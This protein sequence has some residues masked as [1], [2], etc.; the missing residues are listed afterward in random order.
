MTTGSARGPA[1][2]MLQS[3]D[4][5][6][7]RPLLIDALRADPGDHEVRYLLAVCDYR[8]GRLD[9]AKVEFGEV[10]ERN[11]RDCRGY[12]GLGLVAESQNDV[13]AAVRAFR[14]ALEIDGRF[15]PARQK[16][17]ALDPEMAVPS[18]ATADASEVPSSI[19]RPVRLRTLVSPVVRLIR[20]V[21]LVVLLL[22]LTLSLAYAVVAAWSLL[23]DTENIDVDEAKY[24]GLLFA[25]AALVLLVLVRVAWRAGA[26]RLRGV[27]RQVGHRQDRAPGGGP[28]SAG[29]LVHA[30][31]FTLEVTDANRHRVPLVAVE[32]NGK[33]MR[34]VV[35]NGEEVD[36]RGRPARGNYL[37]AS[38]ARVLSTGQ[39]VTVRGSTVP[40]RIGAVLVWIPLLLVLV[41]IVLSVAALFR[42]S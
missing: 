8:L 23:F 6:R 40:N 9:E 31:S 10:L 15:E 38:H 25:G 14:S 33:R 1:Y 20:T 2:E 4:P 3:G 12:H 37:R 7:A 32:M 18:R 28:R 21:V 35:Q 11:P 42:G 36:V 27:V 22:A 29:V 13:P 41:V 34:G 17:Q 5:A 16:L 24:F 19:T 26:V 39:V 30:L